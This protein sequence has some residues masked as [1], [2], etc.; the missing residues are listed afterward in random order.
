MESEFPG[1]IRVK[2]VAKNILL[3]SLGTQREVV[4]AVMSLFEETCKFSEPNCV[5]FV[6]QYTSLIYVERK[7]ILFS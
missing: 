4:F 6:K 3:G 2:A 5:F 1:I 7:V